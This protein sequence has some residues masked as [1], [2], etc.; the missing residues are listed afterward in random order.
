MRKFKK[1]GLVLFAKKMSDQ[2][3]SEPIN[4]GLR[5]KHLD[6]RNYKNRL[7]F[8]GSFKKPSE[9]RYTKRLEA[10]NANVEV[11]IENPSKKKGFFQSL[12][13][14]GPDDA[15]PQ[16]QFSSSQQQ[17]KKLHMADKTLP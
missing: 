11:Q 6:W 14:S 7:F 3:G 13:T 2:S 4:F 10:R 17:H 9:G 8:E 16:K 1:P 15:A 5:A 12:K